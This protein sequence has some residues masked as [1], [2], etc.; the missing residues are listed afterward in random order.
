MTGGA[1]NDVYYVNVGRDVVTEGNPGGIDEIRTTVTLATLAANVENLRLTG[2]GSMNGTGNGL[3]NTITGNS[4]GNTLSGGG[5]HDT[6]IGLGGGDVLRGGAGNDTLTGSGGPDN[7][8]FS[9]ALNANVDRITDFNRASDTVWLDNAVFTAF[10]TTGVVLPG[11][12]FYSAPGATAAHDLNDRIIYNSTSGR[13]YY[14]ADGNA[15]S[16]APIHFA[17]LTGAPVVT[18]ADFFII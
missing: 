7:F 9:S 11:A 6:L 17:T 12:A 8:E 16:S 14:D 5:Q 4:A 18:A 15:A 3:A 1:G 2:S 10:A 13:L